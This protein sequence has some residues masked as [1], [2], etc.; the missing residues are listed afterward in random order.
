MSILSELPQRLRR[1]TSGGAYVPQIDGLRFLSVMP[2]LFFHSGLRAGRMMPDPVA[3]EATITAWFPFAGFAVTLFF[4]I[5]GYI[6]AYPFL[7]GRPPKLSHFYKRRLLRLEP[8]YFVVMIGCFVIL[9]LYTPVSAPNFTFTEAPLWQSL[10]ASLTYS[11]GLIFGQ[12][13]RLNPPAWT[14][15]R[16]VQFYLLAPFLIMAY[17]SIKNRALRLWFGGFALLALIVLGETLR[18]QL[19]FEHPL[20]H[21]LFGESYGFILG[22]MVCDYSVAVRPFEQPPRR[23]YDVL[24]VVG[25]I[26]MMLTGTAELRNIQ[27]GYSEPTLAIATG[28]L[29]AFAR[30]SCIFL[31]F[32]GAARG[33]TG[34]VLLASPWVALIGGACYS[35]YLLHLPLMHAMAAALERQFQPDSLIVATALCWAILVPACIA[36]GLMFYA[37]IERPCMRPKWPSELAMA[38]R[39]VLASVRRLGRRQATTPNAAD[40]QPVALAVTERL[41]ER[42]N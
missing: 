3:G 22:V 28:S 2:I 41:H 39:R 20:R 40:A 35:I 11:H 9:S 32:L 31:V 26:G 12:S 34:R 33:T 4:F 6:I 13:P 27:F 30:A 42:V 7:A 29:N 23:R 38:A 18:H 19:P 10:A 25:Y 15:E 37:L 36:V 5:S 24:L 1:V 8:P 16:E 14:L 21:T 17:L